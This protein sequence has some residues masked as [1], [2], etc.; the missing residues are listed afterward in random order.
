MQNPHL[1]H[2]DFQF[3]S[4]DVAQTLP[5][6]RASPSLLSPDLDFLSLAL[7]SFDCW[8]NLCFGHSKTGKYWVKRWQENPKLWQKNFVLIWYFFHIDIFHSLL[9]G[10]NTKSTKCAQKVPRGT[11]LGDCH[12]FLL[13]LL[14]FL[15]NLS[16]AKIRSL[17]CI[18]AKC[19]EG[20]FSNYSKI[21]SGKDEQI[22]CRRQRA[23]LLFSRTH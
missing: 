13:S 21:T 4:G 19:T 14:W 9:T 5:L 8:F 17:F 22:L 23:I 18:W 7:V 10:R 11:Q 3:G 1:L 12:L 2:V 15:V 20:V 16:G 6:V